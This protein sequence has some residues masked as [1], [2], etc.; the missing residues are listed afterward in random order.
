MSNMSD[1]QDM[2][3][4]QITEDEMETLRGAAHG[5]AMLGGDA[6]YSACLRIEGVLARIVARQQTDEPPGR[7]PAS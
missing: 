4:Y 6:A 3:T 7:K 2:M 1:D 5:G